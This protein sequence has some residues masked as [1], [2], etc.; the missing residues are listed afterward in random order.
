MDPF[1]VVASSPFISLLS[2]FSLIRVRLIGPCL[3][4]AEYMGLRGVSLSLVLL[5]ALPSAKST[6]GPSRQF[7]S[8]SRVDSLLGG[9]DLII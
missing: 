8:P 4:K 3:V 9:L 5:S 1:L 6:P 7:Y 2:S